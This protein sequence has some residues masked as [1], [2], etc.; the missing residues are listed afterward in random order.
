MYVV[1]VNVGE[2]WCITG[3]CYLCEEEQTLCT[4]QGLLKGA[5]IYYVTGVGPPIGHPWDI[6]HYP[7]EVMYGRN[8]RTR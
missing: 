2:E 7:H 6:K 5:L 1:F 3:R 8:N 4:E